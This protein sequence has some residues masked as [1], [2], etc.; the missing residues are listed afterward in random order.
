MGLLRFML[1]LA[2]ASGRAKRNS[3]DRYLSQG[4]GRRS[5]L[6]HDRGVPDRAYPKRQ[7]CRTPAPVDG[8][9]FVGTPIV[10]ALLWRRHA[11]VEPHFSGLHQGCNTIWP[12]RHC[13]CLAEGFFRNLPVVFPLLWSSRSHDHNLSS[14]R[15]STKAQIGSDQSVARRYEKPRPMAG[16]SQLGSKNWIS[17]WPRPGIC[18]S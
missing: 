13:L 18:P 8:R 14:N 9:Y 4:A 16:V 7:I 1:A 11:C 10:C 5:A 17:S 2:A 6:L 15:V 12:S 3:R